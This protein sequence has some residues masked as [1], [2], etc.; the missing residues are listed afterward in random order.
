MVVPVDEGDRRGRGAEHALRQIGDTC[1]PAVGGAVE[2][3][4]PVEGAD[5]FLFLRPIDRRGRVV[6][7]CQL[8]RD[9]DGDRPSPGTVGL[10][11]AES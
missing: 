1:E 11:P 2:N 8:G 7:A 3:F 9:G 6:G 10:R 4:E 5:P